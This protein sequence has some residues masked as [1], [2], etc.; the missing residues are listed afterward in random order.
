MTLGTFQPKARMSGDKLDLRQY[1]GRPLLVRTVD[2]DPAFTS[3]TYPN[4]KPVVF[5]DVVDLISGQIYISALWGAGAVVD[6]LKDKAG[7][8]EVVAVKA[9]N[10]PSTKRAGTHYV[11][12]FPLEGGEHEAAV[13]WYDANWAIVDQTRAQRQAAAAPAQAPQGPP[14]GQTTAQQFQPSGPTSGQQFN[15][16]PQNQFPAGQ[17]QYNQAPA[18]QFGAPATQPPPNPAYQ[19]SPVYAPVA[20]GP[21]QGYTVGQPAPAPQQFGA[22]QAQAAPPQ[23][24]APAQGFGAPQGGVFSDVPPGPPAGAAPQFAPP[25]GH[26]PAA[27]AAALNHLNQTVQQPQG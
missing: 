19:A 11:A 4:A 17:P 18:T 15:P 14:V 25:Q 22:P 9:A 7:T 8:E 1:A 21:A 13:A 27:A 20:Q 24:Y 26:D 16:T 10:V 5:V 12:L 23:Q 2:Y 6:N 3:P